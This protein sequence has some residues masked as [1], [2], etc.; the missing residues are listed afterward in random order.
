MALR[1]AHRACLLETG[2]LVIEGPAS[3][4]ISNQRVREAYLGAA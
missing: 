3:E 1:L 4:L 2:N